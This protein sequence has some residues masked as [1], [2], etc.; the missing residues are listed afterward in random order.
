MS[1][2][3]ELTEAELL[4]FAEAHGVHAVNGDIDGLA[5]DIIPSQRYK[6]DA[7]AALLPNPVVKATVVQAGE[8]DGNLGVVVVE[9]AGED[10]SSQKIRSIW[11]RRQPIP[12][13]IDYRPVD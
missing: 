9:Y 12:Q 2:N 8:L 7:V 10:G 1:E 3:A 5:N 13:I 11:E 6:L 4:S